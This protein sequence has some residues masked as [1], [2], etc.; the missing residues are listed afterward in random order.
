MIMAGG[1][2]RGTAG[3]VPSPGAEMPMEPGQVASEAGH[4]SDVLLRSLALW[5]G[6]R[7]KTRKKSG[8]GS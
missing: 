5:S 8:F 3:G 1:S 7:S 2:R 4:V 6:S